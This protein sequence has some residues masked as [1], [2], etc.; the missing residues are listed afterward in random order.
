MLAI[1]VAVGAPAVIV[2]QGHVL[3][4]WTV[5]RAVD[6]TA[7][8]P[9]VWLTRPPVYPGETRADR[10]LGRSRSAQLV[11]L[12]LLGGAVLI[13]LLLVEIFLAAVGVSLRSIPLPPCAASG[14]PPI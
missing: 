5:A 14:C 10:W 11:S 1:S 2:A 3:R 13:Y 8:P 4:G 9:W 6:V 7:V 12:T